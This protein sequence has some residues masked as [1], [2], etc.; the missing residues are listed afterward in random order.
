MTFFKGFFE[1]RYQGHVTSVVEHWMTKGRWF[2]LVLNCLRVWI[3]KSFWINGADF[4][5]KQFNLIYAKFFSASVNFLQGQ[6]P[7]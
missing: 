1:S 3:D 2:Y 7:L 4:L 6:A 5:L